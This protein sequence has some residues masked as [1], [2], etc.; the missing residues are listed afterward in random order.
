MSFSERTAVIKIAL[1]FLVMVAIATLPTICSTKVE[2]LV[3]AGG[4]F[5]TTDYGTQAR[6]L[7]E[8]C[9][10]GSPTDYSCKTTLPFAVDATCCNNTNAV[11]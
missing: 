8:D 4:R 1:P 6:K 2:K 3:Q 10:S 5:L 11:G 9:G 7:L